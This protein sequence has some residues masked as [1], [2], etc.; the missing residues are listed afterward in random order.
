MKN[1][2]K[3][4]HKK[5]R[6]TILDKPSTTVTAWSPLTKKTTCS[7]ING[8]YPGYPYLNPLGLIKLKKNPPELACRDSIF[9]PFLGGVGLG[10]VTPRW[11]KRAH[12][13]N[14]APTHE[15][16][17]DSWWTVGKLHLLRVRQSNAARRNDTATVEVLSWP[18]I[19]LWW[20]TTR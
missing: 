17:G 16:L 11:K 9:V 5:H 14:R 4:K 13:L 8:G 20:K 3:T 15:V 1:R 12:H 10:T 7:P 18:W 2:C 6:Q 19:F